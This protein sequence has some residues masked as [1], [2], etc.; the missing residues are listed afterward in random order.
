MQ[1]D[2][3]ILRR[4]AGL[5][6]LVL[7]ALVLHIAIGSTSSVSPWD[8]VR[9]LFAGPGGDGVASTIVWDIRLPR[10]LGC[11]LVGA[12]LSVVGAAFQALFR[13]PLAEPYV[14]G[15]SSG[16]AVG[17]TLVVVAGL[18]AFAGGMATLVAGFV[19]GMASL[20]LVIALARRRGVISV[21]TL[22]LAGVVVASMLH[23]VLVLAL[24]MTQRNSEVLRWLMG[25]V[26][27][28]FWSRVG[29]L[30]IGL[31][32]GG[33]LLYRQSRRLNAYAIGET[34]A[35][36]LG[37]ELRHVR[38]IVLMAG[39]AMTAI[40]VGACGVIGFL[41]LVAPH[42]VRKTFGPDLRVVLPGSALVGGV[43]L[44]LADLI[45]QRSVPGI[46]LPVGA[47][48]AVLGAPALLMLLQARE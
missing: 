16:A 40:T 41:G 26:T 38:T 32:V 12:T 11:L 46:E 8:V 4:L 17:G 3:R 22:L 30:A 25:S 48:T 29:V 31:L 18:G 35:Q 47:V 37:V 42:I 13:N 45:A 39:T 2:G 15:V 43:L 9:H 27:P 5:L 28:M 34:T 14:V 6:A 19:G 23:A 10:A 44:L 33:A 1:R 7:A 21:P 20:G 24:L 36:H